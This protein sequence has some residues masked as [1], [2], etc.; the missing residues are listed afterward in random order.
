MPSIQIESEQLLKAVEQLSPHELD[1]FVAQVLAVR[2]QREAPTLSAAE[3]TL[4]LT[5]NS[6]IPEPLQQRYDELIVQRQAEQLTSTEHAEL[7]QL[8]IEIE[9][10]EADRV[11]A[12]ADLARLRGVPLTQLMQ[13][14]GIQPIY[15]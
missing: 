15:A 1:A 8:T 5:I 3:S 13:T 9:Q 4:L 14:L 2:A 7:L 6:A 10:R 12:L 11:A